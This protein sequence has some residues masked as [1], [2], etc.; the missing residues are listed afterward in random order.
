M[1]AEARAQISAAMKERWVQTRKVAK[2]LSDTL[3]DLMDCNVR[4]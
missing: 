1:S 3:A 4:C 2:R